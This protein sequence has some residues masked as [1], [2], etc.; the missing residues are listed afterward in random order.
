M[1]NEAGKSLHE[2]IGGRLRVLREGEGLL[3][4][5]IAR[6]ARGV[7]LAWTQAT[8]AAV[9]RGRRAIDL[10][11]L[12]LLTAVY[13]VPL[14]ALF[15]GRERVQLTETA[16][17]DLGALQRLVRGGRLQLVDVEAP[18]HKWFEPGRRNPGDLASTLADPLLREL[19]DAE[20]AGSGDAEMK[21]AVRLGVSRGD[22][23]RTSHVLWGRSL[24][25]ERD[26]RLAETA[27]A[28]ASRKSL[29][30]LRGHVTRRMLDELRSVLK[31]E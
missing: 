19:E 1:G 29:Q 8:V 22:V 13:D 15:E 6:R 31:D 2:A 11:E 30:V 3:Q 18:I 27:P 9:E 4:D 5:D 21:A 10:A 25:A 17:A 28:Q 14:T 7:G 12:L 16:W 24:T 26:A 20:Q 23:A